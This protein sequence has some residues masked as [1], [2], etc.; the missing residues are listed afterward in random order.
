MNLKDLTR[1]EKIDLLK[2]IESGDAS[3]LN[4]QIVYNGIGTVLI[5]KDGLYYLNDY[6]ENQIPIDLDKFRQ[7]FKGAVFIIPDNGR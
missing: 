5:E 7:T 1:E 4:G 2:K 3:I 6:N